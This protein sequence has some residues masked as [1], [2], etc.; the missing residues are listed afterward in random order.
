MALAGNDGKAMLSGV[1]V[2]DLTTVVFGP[3]A[4]HILQELGCEYAQGYYF[5]KAVDPAAAERLIASQPWCSRS[6][7]P[8]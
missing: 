3:Y 2:L 7:A 5:S 1:R 6:L 4:T 8:V